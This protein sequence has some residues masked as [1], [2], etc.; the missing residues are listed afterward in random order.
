MIAILISANCLESVPAAIYGGVLLLAGVAYLILQ[1]AIIRRQGTHSALARELGRDLKGKLP[2]ALYVVAIPTPFL[3]HWLS[4]A[5]Y[6]LVALIWLV[7]DL[8]I[9]ACLEA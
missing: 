9:E 8:R 2:A 6:A 5:I 3:Q 7:P 1:T 4:T